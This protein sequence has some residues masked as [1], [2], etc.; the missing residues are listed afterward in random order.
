MTSAGGVDTKHPLYSKFEADW[1]Q[2]RDTY[3]G[4]RAV[5]D[6]G[7]RYLPMTSGMKEDGG[8]SNN[9]QSEGWQR[10]Q[11]YKTRAVF[12]DFVADAVETML[13][14]L[15]HKP[16]TIELP[17]Q[18]E[19]L[20]ERATLRNESLEALLRRI[21]EE[22][23]IMGRLGIMLEVPT[24]EGVQLPHIALYQA[25]DIINWDDG[26]RDETAFD[27]PNLVVLDES[28]DE[29]SGLFDWE[30]VTKH[31]VLVLGDVL[32]N[33][34]EAEGATYRAGVVRQDSDG[35][36][37]FDESQLIEP[38]IGGQ[39]FDE[40]PF[41]FINTKDVTSEPDDGPL[42]GLSNLALTAYRGEADYRQSL[43]LQGQD[44]LVTI[45]GNE[46]GD[47]PTR[48]G[49][50]A[51]IELP[52]GADAKYIGV[53]S[54]GLPEQRSALEN[55]YRRGNERARGLVEDVSRAAE[56]GESL[57][58]RVS[59]RTA[60]LNQIAQTGAFAL[61]ELLRKAARWIGANPEAVI[62]TPNDDFVSDT[63]PAQEV[64][65]LMA[66]KAIGAPLSLRSI[67]ASFQRRGLTELTFEEEI[68]E[69]EQEARD[70]LPGAGPVPGEEP[71]PGSTD[72]EGPDPD[73][74]NEEDPDDEDDEQL[75][76]DEG[77]EE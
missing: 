58:V 71:D 49:T 44:T 64:S 26:A 41:E 68:A 70:L 29:R 76:D 59:A 73:D 50:G 27:V 9:A 11:A 55:D 42:L 38:M 15:H 13:G 37:D 16:P 65:Q 63:M 22:Q 8:E 30:H 32:D 67:H 57:R 21:N 19:P 56:S 60:S 40:V 28:E 46:D 45:G 24:G 20:R 4:E 14:V 31:R 74:P 33:E 6:K 1:V 7:T 47:A 66:G 18:L 10:Y 35:G 25:E 77:D 23:L 5:K 34:G 17:E 43:F 36:G 62:V 3:R 61:Q 69:M 2:L 75:D 54:S 39:R 53:D 51:Q 12:P 72:P 48:T 52:L